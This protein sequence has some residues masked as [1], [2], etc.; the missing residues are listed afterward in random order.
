[1]S[2]DERIIF[3]LGTDLRATLQ[4]YAAHYER[5]EADVI[6]EA[7]CLFLETKG[8]RPVRKKGVKKKRK[9]RS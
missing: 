9:P 8:Y 4:D 6:R 2:K 7:L 1:M 3:R 5:S